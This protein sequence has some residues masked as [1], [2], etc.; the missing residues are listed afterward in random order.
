[1]A[2]R[3]VC[4]MAGTISLLPNTGSISLFFFERSAS[5]WHIVVKSVKLC[6]DPRA[7]HWVAIFLLSLSI[8]AQIHA[9][10]T[11]EVTDCIEQ[12]RIRSAGSHRIFD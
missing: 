1:M 3:L 5:S 8:C 4:A 2:W 11:G 9:R 12:L 7:P 6:S 10:H